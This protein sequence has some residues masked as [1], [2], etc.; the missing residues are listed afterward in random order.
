[1]VRTHDAV[2]DRS[3]IRQDPAAPSGHA[4]LGSGSEPIRLRAPS[5]RRRSS[6]RSPPSD[7]A[8]RRDRAR[9]GSPEHPRGRRLLGRGPGLERRLRPRHARDRRHPR[10]V[11]GL[12]RCFEGLRR[13]FGEGFSTIREAPNAADAGRISG[14]QGGGRATRPEATKWTAKT[15]VEPIRRTFET[16][17]DTAVPSDTPVRRAVASPNGRPPS[18]A[19]SFA[20]TSAGQRRAGTSLSRAEADRH[21]RP[22]ARRTKARDPAAA[23]VRRRR[24]RRRGLRPHPGRAPRP[25]LHARPRPCQSAL[26][27]E[28]LNKGTS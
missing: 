24:L 14:P 20:L 22:A 10:R 9:H 15:P 2:E 23:P 25:R 1:M 3:S 11:P 13:R 4:R 5:L 6:S 28:S 7:A 26:R 17:S 16:A 27:T 8:P 21:P 12:R 19:A 18:G